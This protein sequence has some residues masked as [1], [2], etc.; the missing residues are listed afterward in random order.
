MKKI[1]VVVFCFG[2]CSFVSFSAPPKLDWV[3]SSPDRKELIVVRK[4]TGIPINEQDVLELAGVDQARVIPQSRERYDDLVKEYLDASSDSLNYS[5]TFWDIVKRSE[6]DLKFSVV[7]DS[8]IDEWIKETK[9][10]VGWLMEDHHRFFVAKMVVKFFS[11]W[12]ECLDE[13]QEAASAANL[14]EEFHIDRLNKELNK[15]LD[16]TVNRGKKYI[17]WRFD[18]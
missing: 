7:S 11:A 2:G 3:Y 15:L 1:M 16:N 4:D 9:E 6:I 5:S 13:I 12:K 18:V 10:F 17:Q 8:K 14:R